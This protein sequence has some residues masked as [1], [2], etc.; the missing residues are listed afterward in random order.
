MTTFAKATPLKVRLNVYESWFSLNNN[1]I[2][3]RRPAPK[4][5]DRPP[6][7]ALTDGNNPLNK[8]E[9]YRNLGRLT[10]EESRCLKKIPYMAT[11]LAHDSVKIQSKASW[12]MG[13]IYPEG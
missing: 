4:W 5:R 8:A 10:G 7:A 12:E 11:I 9:I 2:A 3:Q 6:T 13:L 1:I